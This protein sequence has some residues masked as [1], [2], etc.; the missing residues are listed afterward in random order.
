MRW[1]IQVQLLVPMLIVV[2]LGIVL[3]G[4][5]GAHFGRRWAQAQQE[6]NLH[7]VV[8]ALT[9]TVYPLNH[10]V[11]VKMR[12]L[13]GAEFAL[14]DASSQP[15]ESTL[16][17]STPVLDTLRRLPAAGQWTELAQSPT[18]TL[19]GTTYRAG[20]LPLQRR[21]SS[22]GPASLVVLFP[23]DRRWAVA[24]QI[25]YP[26]AV[27][28]AVTALVAILTTTLLARR[29][30][31]PIQ[32]L[33]KR[34][35]AIADGDFRPVELGP[36]NDEIRDLGLSINRM[37]EQLGRFEDEVRRSERLRTLGQLGAGM[38][39]QLRNA[40]TG[41]LMAIEL[42]MRK[43]PEDATSETLGVARRQMKLMESYLQRFLTL[44]RPG[45]HVRQRVSLA[46]LL[47][48]VLE[49]VRPAS[50]H[51]KIRLDHRV[52]EEPLYVDGEAETLRQLV[53]NLL[54]NAVEAIGSQPEG[55]PRI[56]V[57][58]AR[59]DGHALLTVEDSGPGPNPE[60]AARIFEPF[61]TGKPDGTGL[62]LWVAK[63]IVADHQGT[64]TWRREHERTCFTVELPLQPLRDNDGAPACGG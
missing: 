46:A 16:P 34:A 41:A 38:A 45:P 18:V 12:G 6:Q 30:V 61:V 35:A 11:L 14:L 55:E 3:S 32:Q 39:H 7:R 53:L 50:N 10:T 36:R 22:T 21:V 9:D 62:G 51:A 40:A 52:S 27:A 2:T 28:G 64:L 59:R 47:H 17:I 26:S 23:E 57:T 58:L 42:H 43:C 63:E 48:D 19:A 44:G 24:Q 49:L 5:A 1:P 56:V 29:F 37:T 31:Q 8:S 4:L 33:R 25:V 54:M 15:V 60:V 20:R 13:S